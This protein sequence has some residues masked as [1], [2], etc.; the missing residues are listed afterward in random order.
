MTKFVIR[1][2]LQAIPTL[3]GIT[4]FSYGLIVLA[5]G[6]PVAIMTF[7]PNMTQEDRAAMEARLGV[8]DPWIL[9]YFRWLVGDDWMVVEEVTW[10]QVD[11]PEEGIQG[12]LSEKQ[13]GFDDETGD[14]QLVASRQPLRAGPT[15]D[16]EIID[17][18]GRRAE[19]NIVDEVD[20][21]VYGDNYGILRG[22]FGRSFQYKENPLV[23]IGERLPAS[24][25]LNIAVIITSLVIGVTTGVLAAVWRGSL[26]D[27]ASR[28]LAV[29]GDAVPNF[30]LAFLLIL[31]FAAP[32]LDI[33]PMGERC[34]YVRGGC[35]PVWQRLEFLVLP[36]AVLA[37][38]GIAAWSRY[39]RASML[40]NINA[41]YVR[42]AR[43]K[44]L[45]GRQVW[46]RHTLR[47]AMIPMATFL[48]PLFVS[49]IGGAVVIEQIFAWPGVGRLLLGAVSAQDYPLIM[50]S[51]IISG[52][53]TVI[54]YLISD[55][56]Y[57]VF[58]P[59]IRF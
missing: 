38:G 29:V 20:V 16:A 42:T 49:V 32:G 53:L 50:A 25:E 15:E 18:V 8:N 27:N 9:Q 39:I 55:V 59:R 1:R 4:F 28:V 35:P 26:F 45:N 22:D 56:L 43:A 47:N 52:I 30:W 21:D 7:D 13:L 11:L 14:P 12:W 10:Y 33:L 41:D 24:I 44:G 57:A 17:R 46:F 34:D 2:I 58:D 5:P 36:T 54:A 31:F 37:L 51:V 3:F 23:L 40:E 48:G 19:F 6:D